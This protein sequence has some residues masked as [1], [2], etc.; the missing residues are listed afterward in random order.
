MLHLFIGIDTASAKAKARTDA[1][2]EVVMF[3]EGA[4]AFD[5]APSFLVSQGLFSTTVTLLLDRPFETT[6]GRALIEAHAAALHTSKTAVYLIEGA[7]SAEQ[8][9]LFPKNVTMTNFGTPEKEERLLPFAMSNAFIGG[10]RKRAWIEFRKLITNGTSPEEIHGTLSWAVRSAFIASKTKSANEADLKPFVYT[11]FKRAAEKLGA[12]KIETL[13]RELVVV[14]H[15]AR[16]GQGDM[17][18]GLER[19]IL[20]KT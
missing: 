19:L 15:R 8:R 7:L 11:K 13:S 2:G 5:T 3:G 12:Q 1:K 14:Y 6:D 9:K 4:N 18:L 20:E 10:D 17:A 16:S